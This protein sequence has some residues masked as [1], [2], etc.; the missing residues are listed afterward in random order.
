MRQHTTVRSPISTEPHPPT[1]ATS[2]GGEIQFGQV[3]AQLWVEVK[4][5][6]A[7]RYAASFLDGR[8]AHRNK[9]ATTTTHRSPHQNVTH[10]RWC[11]WRNP[12]TPA[13]Q[14]RVDC[15]VVAQADHCW[16]TSSH[17]WTTRPTQPAG[18]LIEV[19]HGPWMP[20]GCEQTKPNCWSIIAYAC[21][22]SLPP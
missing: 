12:T 17:A 6:L 9:Q 21:S 7:C 3:C 15:G 18:A 8:P 11:H 16:P 1:A 13:V 14:E 20:L 2:L 10:Q 4:V 19:H 22:C 5:P